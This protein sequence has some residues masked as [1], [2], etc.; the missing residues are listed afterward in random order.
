VQKERAVSRA[1]GESDGPAH[2]H[3]RRDDKP[4]LLD[5]ELVE[6]LRDETLRAILREVVRLPERERRIM[7]NIVRQFEEF[8][9]PK[10]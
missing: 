10:T 7:L 2:P 5:E 6:A 3:G 1:R 9:D 8:E 4:A